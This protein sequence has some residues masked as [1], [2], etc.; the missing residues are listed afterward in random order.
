MLQ[1]TTLSFAINA[2]LPRFK[3]LQQLYNALLEAGWMIIESKEGSISRLWNW[4]A[5]KA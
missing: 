3:A 5:I 2:A 1:R 4:V